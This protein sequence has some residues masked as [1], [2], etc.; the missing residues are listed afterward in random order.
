MMQTATS[1]ME[2]EERRD[3]RGGSG[4]QS[5]TMMTTTAQPKEKE[6]ILPPPMHP[7][8]RIKWTLSGW[9]IL[10]TSRLPLG[11]SS[12]EETAL[13]LDYI[14]RRCI[15]C[16]DGGKKLPMPSP[17]I[18]S[19]ETLEASSSTTATMTVSPSPT[20]SAV[21]AEERY[22]HCRRH[23]RLD[24]PVE[25]ESRYCARPGKTDLVHDEEVAADPITVDDDAFS[26]ETTAANIFEEANETSPSSSSTRRAPDQGGG[27]GQC[28]QLRPTT[29]T[30]NPHTMSSQPNNRCRRFINCFCCICLTIFVGGLLAAF[31][32]ICI[33]SLYIIFKNFFF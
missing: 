12:R 31:T 3:P 33:Y 10:T 28:H 19:D 8:R 6:T 30:A 14:T 23:R 13:M 5:K 11:L 32:T 15:F 26:A 25:M 1:A 4:S 29:M 21:T 17:P 24:D 9:P 27:H 16:D 2:R 7:P 22:L 20:S 18:I